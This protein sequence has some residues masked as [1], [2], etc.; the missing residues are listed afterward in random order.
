RST[1]QLMGALGAFTI[2]FGLVGGDWFWLMLALIPAG[3]LCAPSLTASVETVS[4]WVP[5]GA[6]GEAMGLHGTALT[7][8]VAAGAPVAGAVIDAFGAAWGFA[9]GGGVT[10][11]LVLAAVP[12][13]PR[14][15]VARPVVE[16][17]EP[18][19]RNEVESV[20]AAV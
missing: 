9:L 12:F 10:I 5:A 11:L 2:P 18:V 7:V 14:T 20:P 3:L 16:P 19:A 1:L 13:W 8:G 15:P 4:A 6:R 17:A